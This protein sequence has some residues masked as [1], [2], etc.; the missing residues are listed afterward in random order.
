MPATLLSPAQIERLVE[1]QAHLMAPSPA[2][3]RL[4]DLTSDPD[5]EV[6][7]R[8]I[9]DILQSEPALAAQV[10]QWVNSAIFSLPSPVSDI[11][12]A[13]P[14]LG[15]NRVRALALS[16]AFFNK[17][18]KEE[19]A[20]YG[21]KGL[22]FCLHGL[23][24]AL[25]AAY[26]MKQ[27]NPAREG[28]AF[29]SGLLHD[30]GMLLMG[31][32]V[33]NLEIQKPLLPA[34]RPLCAIERERFGVDHASLGGTLAGH[35]RLSPEQK[36]VIADHHRE[37]GHRLEMEQMNRFARPGD[38]VIPPQQPVDELPVMVQI[39][40]R[41]SER[42][43]MICTATSQEQDLRRFRQIMP[44]EA[45]YTALEDEMDRAAAMLAGMFGHN[46]P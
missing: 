33:E 24:T 21:I 32:V 30:I 13:I 28:D 34:D 41:C 11:G 8:Q 1:R 42:R 10:L 27:R 44:D 35:W 31:G 46:G 15:L 17:A 19:M 38:P 6:P 2:V 45:S 20:T 4:L 5:L 16:Q 7:S 37:P 9:A 25:G 23:E 12:R 26:L 3:Q 18:A 29:T 40:D 43:L 14:L 36:G 39:A 22:T